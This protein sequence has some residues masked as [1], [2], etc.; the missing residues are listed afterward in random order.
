MVQIFKIFDNFL[1]TYLNFFFKKIKIIYSE[2][3]FK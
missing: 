2:N 3:K 1:L